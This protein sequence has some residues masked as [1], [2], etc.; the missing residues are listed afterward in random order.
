[1]CARRPV[2]YISGRTSP[3]PEEVKAAKQAYSG[4][5]ASDASD[6]K[7]HK[8]VLLRRGGLAAM[9]QA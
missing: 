4:L 6:L 2:A 3:S 9:T 5:R 7:L 8:G 1:M